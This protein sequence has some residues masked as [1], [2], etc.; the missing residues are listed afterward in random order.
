MTSYN[1]L[2]VASM[3]SGQPEDVSKILGNFNAIAAVINGHIDDTN[4]ASG[5]IFDPAKIK[6]NGA[7]V[8][9]AL[10]WGGST[11]VPGGIL[12]S[13]IVDAKGDLIAGT[14]NDTIA[15][16]PVGADGTF[17]KADSAQS[18]GMS[19]AS[20]AT[21]PGYGT[22]LPGSPV[23]SQEYILV[24]STTAPTYIWRFRYNAGNAGTYKWECIGGAPIIIETTN[25]D[26]TSSATYVALANAGPSFVLPRAG[27]YNVCI[28]FTKGTTSAGNSVLIRMSYD[29]GGTGAVDADSV[30]WMGPSAGSNPEYSVARE[31]RKTFATAVTLTSKYKSDGT[32]SNGF[33][34]RWMSVMPVMV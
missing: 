10:V 9:Q 18:T 24:D 25:N 6:Q 17:L 11:W 14:A 19:W 8:G 23:D 33:K 32:N 20:V 34:N 21:L 29:I 27:I 5:L 31:Q 2:D 16:L 15:R 26:A 1:V 7:T 13:G 4:F 28:G 22:S 3:V 30:Q 12:T